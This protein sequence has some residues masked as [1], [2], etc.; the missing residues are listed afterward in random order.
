ML[1]DV[2][3][4]L[5]EKGDKED[6]NSSYSCNAKK[7]QNKTWVHHK[8]YSLKYWENSKSVAAKED[9]AKYSPLSPN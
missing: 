6:Q 4:R 7:P 3:K 5:K 8:S 2:Q 1:L 9:K